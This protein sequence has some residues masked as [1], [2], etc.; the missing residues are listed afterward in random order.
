[1]MKINWAIFV[2]IC[3]AVLEKSNSKVKLC[4][5]L[6]QKIGEVKGAKYFMNIFLTK[7]KLN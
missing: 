3:I 1:M 2:A 6:E 7:S 4:L 5:I